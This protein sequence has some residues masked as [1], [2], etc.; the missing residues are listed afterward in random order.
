VRKTGLEK[1]VI[2]YQSSGSRGIYLA[3]TW[4]KMVKTGVWFANVLKE[5]S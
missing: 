5:Q 4:D 3:V 2:M 1:G